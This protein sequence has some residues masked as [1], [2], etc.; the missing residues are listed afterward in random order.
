MGIEK[1][2]NRRRGK[3]ERRWLDIVRADLRENDCWGGG[4]CTAERQRD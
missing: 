2:G 3:P 1:E 4:K